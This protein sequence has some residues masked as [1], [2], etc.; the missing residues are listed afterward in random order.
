M[1]AM[2]WKSLKIARLGENT[3]RLTLL[4]WSNDSEMIMV[5]MFNEILRKN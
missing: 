5:L 3:G 4:F 2:T 1:C